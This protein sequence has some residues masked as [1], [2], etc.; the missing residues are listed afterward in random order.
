MLRFFQL[1]TIAFG[2]IAAVVSFFLFLKFVKSRKKLGRA[3]AFMLAG[4]FTTL[5]ATV[6]FSVITIGA[7]GRPTPVQEIM[8]RWVIFSVTCASTLYLHGVLKGEDDKLHEERERRDVL[9]RELLDEM[10]TA[11]QLVSDGSSDVE[12][13]EQLH[14]SCC[15]RAG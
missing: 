5:T 1:G 14:S 12:H 11:K 7:I 10:R 9:C 2:V 4:E 3:V 13:L 15:L 6:V 8:L